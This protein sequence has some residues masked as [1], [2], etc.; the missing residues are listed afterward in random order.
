VSKKKE[1]G[2]VGVVWVGEGKRSNALQFQTL[3][4]RGL[5]RLVVGS[6]QKGVPL[7][8][9]KKEVIGERGGGKTKQKQKKPKVKKKFL[10][11]GDWG[12]KTKGEKEGRKKKGG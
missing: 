12:R 2:L 11:V 6:L 9:K 4:R 10:K 5:R 7:I 8:R 3:N 1:G